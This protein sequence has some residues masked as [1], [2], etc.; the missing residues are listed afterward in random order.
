MY[1]YIYI[2][3]YNGSSGSKMESLVQL[4]QKILLAVGFIIW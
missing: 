4:Q 2:Y 1:I 3:I